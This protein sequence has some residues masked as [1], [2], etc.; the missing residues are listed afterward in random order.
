MRSDT[1]VILI[2]IAYALSNNVILPFSFW[3]TRFSF[4]YC[5]ITNTRR[6]F[7]GNLCI[8]TAREMYFNLVFVSDYFKCNSP[9]F[10]SLV[11]SNLVKYLRNLLI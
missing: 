9:P 3:R 2:E 1:S 6:S 11:I 4:A 8:R 7:F 5:D 10:F